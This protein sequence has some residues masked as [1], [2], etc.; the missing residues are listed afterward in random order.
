MST[1]FHILLYS[2]TVT[3]TIDFNGVHIFISFQREKTLLQEYKHS[4]KSNVFVDRRI[5]EN[6]SRMDPER[7][8]AL[9]IAAEKKRQF[10]KVIIS[11]C[12][13]HPGLYINMCM[14]QLSH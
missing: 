2:H 6:N 7:K 1:W 11:P 9:R 3:S 4:Y 12:F 13:S 10:S 8:I 5:G 14:L